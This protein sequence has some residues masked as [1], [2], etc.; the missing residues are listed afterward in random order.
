MDKISIYIHLPWC[1]KK[2]LYC[3]FNSFEGFNKELEKKYLQALLLD[4]EY[5]LTI[6]KD[7]TITSIFFGGGTPSLFASSSIEKIITYLANKSV[8]SNSIEI[9]LEANP[10]TLDIKKIKSYKALGINRLSLGIQSFNDKYLNKIGRI[11][12]SSDAKNSI[13]KAKA[14]FDNINLD[15][16]F[17]LPFQTTSE[18]IEDIDTAASFEPSH[19]SY[20]E[21][22]IEPNTYF[23]SHNPFP[24]NYQDYHQSYELL[25]KTLSNHGF[26]RYEVSAYV[27]N[28]SSMKKCLHNIHYWQYGDYLGIG[29]GA[30]SKIT[31]SKK[32][33]RIEKT[34]DPMSYINKL[35]KKEYDSVINIKPVNPSEIPV[36][37]MMNALRLKQ[38]FNI[39]LFETTTG[40]KINKI[41]PQLVR[42]QELK[43][44]KVAKNKIIPTAFGFR[45]LNY[46]NQLFI[47]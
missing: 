14:V 30:H 19:I 17:A 5:S 2:C 23:Y 13:K 28:K 10:G 47:Q 38:G 22:T 3:D 41:K 44:I 9:T 42:A 46:L 8:F 34:K 29:A 16:M 12:N 1:I 35:N 43:L 20:Y 27:N 37:F 7:K 4:I 36:E 31:D 6:L 33:Y 40:I 32:I 24:K 26:S 11:H 18:A 15:L 25:I 21:L 39:H 45:N